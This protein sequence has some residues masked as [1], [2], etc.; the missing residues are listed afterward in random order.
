M[1]L[2]CPHCGKWIVEAKVDV[3]RHRRLLSEPSRK[4]WW[5]GSHAGGGGMVF[6]KLS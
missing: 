6:Q 1:K 3:E 2:L 5:L 4:Q